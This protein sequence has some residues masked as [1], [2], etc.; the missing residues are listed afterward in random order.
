MTNVGGIKVTG[1]SYPARIWHDYMAG[2]LEDAPVVNFTAPNRSLIP[3]GHYLKDDKISGDPE[4]T[5][6][7]IP[8]ST[9]PTTARTSTTF[10]PL[11]GRTLPTRPDRPRRTTTPTTERPDCFPFCD[12]DDPPS[13]ED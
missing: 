2:A 8:R 10:D 3:A 4:P 1:G 9:T 12:E 5:S 11:D 6:S 7:T 13:G